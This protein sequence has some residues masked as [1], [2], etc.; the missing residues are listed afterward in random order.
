M[1]ERQDSRDSP[2]RDERH[3]PLLR[4]NENHRLWRPPGERHPL[5]VSEVALWCVDAIANSVF[6]VSVEDG[7]SAGFECARHA[8][9]V[10]EH[11]ILPLSGHRSI[12]VSAIRH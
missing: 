9:E 11:S 12:S 7:P 10:A 6:P 8:P 2:Q 4:D 1:L 5:D 3:G